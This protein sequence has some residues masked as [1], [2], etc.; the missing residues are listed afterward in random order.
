MKNRRSCARKAKTCTTQQSAVPALDGRTKGAKREA[1]PD[2]NSP[3]KR[4]R[5]HKSEPQTASEYNLCKRLSKRKGREDEEGQSSQKTNKN[6]DKVPR[7][8]KT[9]KLDPKSEFEAKYAQHNALG[10]GGFGLVFAGYRRTDNL[11]VAIKHIP[12]DKVSCTEDYKGQRLAAEVAVMLKLGNGKEGSVGTSAP[13]SLL[14]WYNTDEE[15]ILVLERPVPSEDLFEYINNKEDDLDE[16]EA[17]IIIKQLVE[18]AKHLEDNSIFHRDIKPENILIETGSDVP[19]VRLIDF[20][21]SCFFKKE[22]SFSVF[23]GTAEHIPPEWYTTSVYKPGPTTVWQMGVVL[24][25]ILHDSFDTIKFFKD[26]LDIND[27]VSS[28]CMDFL[29]KCLDKDPEQR[30]TLEQLRLHSWLI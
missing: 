15:L 14:D 4:I 5:V 12:K 3:R 19:Q 18:A 26:E 8:K 17:K 22:S 24:Y 20:G 30:P 28:D 2:V 1:S 29:G 6:C 11:P 27:K 9:K 25:E 10:E 23:C 21:L 16:K 7:S 13:V